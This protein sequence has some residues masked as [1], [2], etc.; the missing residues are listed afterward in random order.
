VFDLGLVHAKELW[1]DQGA[2]DR[3]FSSEHIAQWRAAWP[4]LDIRE[5]NLSLYEVGEP[6]TT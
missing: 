3:H 2:L 6:R 1:V 5:R 4:S